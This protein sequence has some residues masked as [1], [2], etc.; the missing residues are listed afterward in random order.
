MAVKRETRPNM[1]VLAGLPRA[2]EARA[3][4]LSLCSCLWEVYVFIR[5][6]TTLDGEW[7]PLQSEIKVELGL[8][9]VAQSR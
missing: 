8:S 2:V 5:H 1:A 6:V 9:K 3:K 4:F 7:G